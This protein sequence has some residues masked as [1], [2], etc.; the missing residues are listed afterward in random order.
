MKPEKMKVSVLAGGVSGEREVSLRSGAAVAK[1]LRSIGVKVLEVDVKEK[2]VKVP[3]GTDICFLALH[4]TYGEDGEVQ[5]ELEAA[6]MPF[7]G[8]GSEASAL[9]FDKLKARD[10][11]LAAGVPMAESQEWTP[12]CDWKPPYVLKPV[13]SGSSLGTFLVRTEA[14]AKKAVKEAKMWKDGGM[15]IERL[16]EGAEMTIGILGEQALPVMEVRPAKG[17]YD[18]QNKYTSGATQYL[19]PAPIPKE[20]AQELQELA[21]KAH[22][23]LGCEVLSRVDIMVDAEGKPHVLEVN[24]LPGMTDLSL[25]PKAG[26]A[27]GIDFT[28]QCLRTLELS[29]ARFH[30]GAKV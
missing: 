15:M 14:E 21:L 3:Q 26:R 20:K 30:K 19:C 9:A 12:A 18:Y 27:A 7:T 24:T 4:G 16:I 17:F 13:A 1:A 10:A 25:L 22:R 5:R 23:A 29:W 6:G 8:S 2:G 28:T 11:M